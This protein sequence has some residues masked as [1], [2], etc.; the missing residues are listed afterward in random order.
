MNFLEETYVAGATITEEQV[1]RGLRDLLGAG[2]GQLA[3]DTLM[4][5]GEARVRDTNGTR[6]VISSV[7]GGYRVS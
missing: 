5:D 7:R 6:W 4:E 3:Y 1:R 2:V